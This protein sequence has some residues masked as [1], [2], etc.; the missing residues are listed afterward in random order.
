M[1]AVWP[2]QRSPTLVVSAGT[3]LTADAI[4]DG[5]RH[6]GGLILPGRAML[7]SLVTPAARLVGDRPQGLDG[8]GLL[9]GVIDRAW[10]QLAAHSSTSPR[11]ILT[12]G[13]APTIAAHVSADAELVP[14]LV[15]KGL[16]VI[17]ATDS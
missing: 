7:A 16:A 4:A 3:A 5:G 8:P 6:L 15:L 1:L 13:D 10:A 2:I 17:T 12:G 14:D 9:G 11:L